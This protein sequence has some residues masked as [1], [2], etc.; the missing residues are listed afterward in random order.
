M[1]YSIGELSKI[2]GVSEHTLRFYERE[3]LIKVNRDDNNIRVYSE[4]NKTW[5]EA[6]LHL[7]KTGMS[8]KDMKQFAMWGHVGNETMGERLDLLKNHRKKVVEELKKLQQSL[9][10]LDDKITFYENELGD[11]FSK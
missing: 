10:F 9:E 4:E 11:C 3:G 1:T 2:V 5:V 8:L 7:K 6:L